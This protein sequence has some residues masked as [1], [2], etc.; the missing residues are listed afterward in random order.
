MD[1]SSGRIFARRLRANRENRSGGG[2]MT[3]AER[4]QWL[5]DREQIKE[6]VYRY[7]VAVD[8]RD[9][10]LFRSLFTDEVDLLLTTAVRPGRPRQ[11]V[12]ADTFTKGVDKVI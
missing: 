6:T 8:S 12:N 3:D 1:G 5:V 11:I 10:Q 7:P 9:W 4:L 2:N